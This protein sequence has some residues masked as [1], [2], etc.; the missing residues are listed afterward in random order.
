MSK[1]SPRMLAVNNPRTGRA[2]YEFQVPSAAEMAALAAG[3]RNAQPAWAARGVEKRAE[4][5]RRWADALEARRDALIAAEAT[6]TGRL[7]I[8]REIVM[9]MIA[10]VRA[11]SQMAPAQIAAAHRQGQSGVRPTVHFE[12]QLC[13]YPLVGVISPWN[14]PLFLATI[15]AIPALL[16]GCS[17]MVKPS[18]HAPRIV[19]PLVDSIRA[20]PEL[21]EV[22]AFVRGAAE[23]GQQLIEQVDVVCFTGSVPNGRKVGEACARRFIPAFLELGGKDPAIVTASADIERAA[24]AVLRGGVLN[25]GQI[26]HSIER[27]YVARG[28]FDR[29]VARLVELASAI[30]LSY[31]AESGGHI[32]PFIMPR[33]AAI[34]DEQLDDALARGARI[35]CG[36]KS[37]VHG[38]GVYMRPTVLVGVDPGMKIMQDET[39]G[40]VLPV[41]PFDSEEDAIRLANDSEFGLS[42]AVIAGSLDEARR[43][44]ARINAGAV[45]LQD[46]TLSNTILLDTEK[47]YFGSSGLGEPRTGP[48]AILRYLRRKAIIINTG[49]PAC[50]ASLGEERAG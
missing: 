31:P 1:E 24:Q 8:S 19:D 9:R 41:I 12:T 10:N 22:F 13:P 3:L 46:T 25:T 23:T 17:V 2:D 45:T 27:V 47:C 20:V 30:R 32:G 39:F 16:A 5:M 18:E 43:I 29:F 44:G 36:G 38:G 48:S 11:W 28:I 49:E 34:V 37:E 50:M 14:A 35:L 7:R 4:I 42:G 6:D 33:Q 21:A 40:P 15:D 26:C